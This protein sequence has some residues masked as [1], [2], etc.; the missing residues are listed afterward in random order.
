MMY[1]DKIGQVAGKIWHFLN[2]HGTTT[3]AK[4]KKEL[5]AG[6]A[7]CMQGIGWLAKEDKIDFVEKGKSLSVKLR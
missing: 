7:L 3:V 4:L 6:D 1:R 2:E 5:E